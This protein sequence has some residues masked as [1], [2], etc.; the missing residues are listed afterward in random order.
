[1]LSLEPYRFDNGS[2]ERGEIWKQIASNLNGIPDSGLNTSQ[3]GVRTQYDKLI[4]DFVKKERDQK[5]KLLVLMQIM[6]SLI[7]C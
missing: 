2:K 6:M 4:E 7:S 3:R 5:R 1:M